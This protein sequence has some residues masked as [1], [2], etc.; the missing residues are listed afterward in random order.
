MKEEIVNLGD[1]EKKQSARI[2]TIAAEHKVIKRLADL[3]LVPNTQVKILR[4]TI[5]YG[6]LVIQ[7]RGISLALGKGVAKKILVRKL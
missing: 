4:K 7:V 5:F 6:P 1:L 3:G 2:V